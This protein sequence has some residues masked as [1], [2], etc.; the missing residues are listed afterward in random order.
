MQPIPGLNL[1]LFSRSSHFLTETQ[2]KHVTKLILI[3][4][5][6]MITEEETVL[7]EDKTVA[8]LLL[9]RMDESNS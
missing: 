8:T 5:L 4:Y 6:L 1:D 9:T 2:E 7:R 3:D